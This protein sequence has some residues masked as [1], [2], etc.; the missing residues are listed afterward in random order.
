MAA[1]RYVELNPVRAGMVDHAWEYPWSSAGFH[2][3]VCAV[4]PLV[5]EKTLPTLA[6]NW[7]EFLSGG[8]DKEVD[9]LRMATRTG[10]PAGDE[11]FITALSKIAG[12][13]VMCG[14]PGRPRKKQK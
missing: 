8:D 3:G 14:K 7:R 1:A 12:K 2:S 11:V 4:D 10:R 5:K 6:G 9:T 13:N